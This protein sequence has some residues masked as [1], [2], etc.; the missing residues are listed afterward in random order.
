[1]RKSISA[2]FALLIAVSVPVGARG[3][4]W[5]SYRELF[6]RSDLVVIAT[7]RAGTADTN[8]SSVL[9]GLVRQDAQGRQSA[10]LTIGVETPF[11]VSIILKGDQDVEQFVL[12][13]YREV[14]TEVSFNGPTLLHFD[15]S[16]MSKRGSYLMFLIREADGRY[17]PTGGQTDPGLNSVIKIPLDNPIPTFKKDNP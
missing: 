17:A 6:N 12:H 4:V 8:E 1:M 16:D 2:A 5:L 3:V 9:Q 7:P 15:A 11:K 13:H 14:V 10:I